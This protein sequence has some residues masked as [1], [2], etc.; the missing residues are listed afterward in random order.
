MADRIKAVGDIDQCVMRST[1]ELLEEKNDPNLFELK[2]SFNVGIDRLHDAQLLADFDRFSKNHVNI[3]V[4]LLETVLIDG[5]SN[6]IIGLVENLRRQGV[7]I[8][9]DDFGSGHASLASLMAIQP[10]R[11]KIDRSL[12]ADICDCHRARRLITA[13]IEM[14]GALCIETIAEGVESAAQ[15][16]LLQTLGVNYLQGY[17]FARPSQFDAALAQANL[18]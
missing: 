4:E 9:L 7:S 1:L 13:I 2:F 11:I 15:A 16:D 17:Y 10:D 14:A 18:S 3:A 8:E 6:H 5:K 12:V